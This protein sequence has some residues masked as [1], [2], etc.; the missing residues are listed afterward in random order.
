MSTRLARS[1]SSLSSGGP[2]I[3]T[4]LFGLLRPR[5]PGMTSRRMPQN[6]LGTRATL[7]VGK[8]KYTY[9]S[10]PALE[11][12]IARVGAAPRLKESILSLQAP[13]ED[14]ARLA[15]EAGVKTLVLSHLIPADDPEVTESMWLEAA[16]PHFQGRILVGRDLI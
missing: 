11:R 15:Q 16:R 10:L 14:A 9:F 13:V 6:P 3:G 5:R 2:E 12:L 1:S 7:T 8:R 4:P